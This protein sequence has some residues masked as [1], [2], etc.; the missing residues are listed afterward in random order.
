[1]HENLRRG[2]LSSHIGHLLLHLLLLLELLLLLLWL[3]LRDLLIA[4]S[5]LAHRLLLSHSWNLRWLHQQG[6]ASVRDGLNERVVSTPL[7][8]RACFDMHGLLIDIRQGHELA[9]LHLHVEVD[10]RW[11]HGVV[12]RQNDFKWVSR[13]RCPLKDQIVALGLPREIYRKIWLIKIQACDG[14]YLLTQRRLR[15]VGT[16]A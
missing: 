2:C 9:L 3:A 13:R 14:T 15:T 16:I 5:G 1:M 10:A 6:R 8:D 4:P 7:L 12:L 11:R